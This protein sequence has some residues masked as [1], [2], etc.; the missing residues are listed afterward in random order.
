MNPRIAFLFRI[1]EYSFYCSWTK[2][3][4]SLTQSIPTNFG[5]LWA[6]VA[7]LHMQQMDCP[8]YQPIK[9]FFR[10]DHD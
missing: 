8:N 5:K 7:H 6:D 2:F 10:T 4:N 3:L 1:A 9:A